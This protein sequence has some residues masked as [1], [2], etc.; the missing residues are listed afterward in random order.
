VD[1]RGLI[2]RAV[3][4]DRVGQE[5]DARWTV[6]E[7]PRML[8]VRAVHGGL[9]LRQDGRRIAVMHRGRCQ[10]G[11]LGMPVLLVVVVKERGTPRL[12][13][14]EVVEAPPASTV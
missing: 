9:P 2:F 6:D 3:D 13:V 7:A 5:G 11:E 1:D 10:E 8:L 12:G 14:G 4:P